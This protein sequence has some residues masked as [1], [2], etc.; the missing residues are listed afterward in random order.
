[1]KRM[2]NPTEIFTQLQEA[3]LKNSPS[4]ATVFRWFREFNEGERTSIV[5]RPRSGRPSTSV[6][7]SN[8]EAVSKELTENPKQSLRVLAQVLGISK[9]AVRRILLD[10]LDLRKVCSVWVPYRLSDANKIARVE[11]ARQLIR[12]FEDNS[13]EECLRLWA[14]EDETW[15]LFDS[16]ETKQQN[17]AWL[18]VGASRPRIVSPKITN[19]KTMLVVAFTGDGKINIDALRAG[20][21]LNSDGYIE[22]V[23]NTGTKWRTLRSSPTR[24]Q[25]IWWQHDNAR[26]HSAAATRQFFERR[27]V[28]LISQSPYSPDL[29]LCDRW[30]FSELKKTLRKTEFHSADEVRDAALHAFRQLKRERFEEELKHFHEH[31]QHVIHARGDYVV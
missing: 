11:C 5:D 1:M 14:T 7:D 2:K 19:R 9:D 21:A 31:C 20:E 10:H 22:F 3:Q 24:L 12:I 6:I 26:P 23:K 17:K 25:E 8:I 4:R 16:L 18:P 28:Q 27:G 30:L 15:V 13:L 29:N